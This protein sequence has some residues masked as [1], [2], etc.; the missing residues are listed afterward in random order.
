[1]VFKKQVELDV[2]RDLAFLQELWQAPSTESE[3]FDYLCK[4]RYWTV[5]NQTKRGRICAFINKH[6]D[7]NQLSWSRQAS[8]AFEFQ[9]EPRTNSTKADADKG[10]NYKVARS[11][12]LSTGHSQK[13]VLSNI[14]TLEINEHHRGV[15]R[16][17]RFK[18]AIDSYLSGVAYELKKGSIDERLFAEQSLRVGFSSFGVGDVSIACGDAILGGNKMRG[19][20]NLGRRGWIYAKLFDAATGRRIGEYKAYRTRQYVGFDPNPSK[21]FF[22]EIPLDVDGGGELVNARIELHSG[23]TDALLF[24]TNAVLQ[25]WVW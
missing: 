5:E 7:S 23:F 14:A 25:T 19:W 6:D 21:R 8:I 13:L 17:H 20:I 12:H 24:E 11:G 4:S 18:K 3:F 16:S 15:A 10:D 9:G 22:F 1:M 2:S